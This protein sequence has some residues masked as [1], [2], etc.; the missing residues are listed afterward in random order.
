MTQ[1]LVAGCSFSDYTKVQ[2]VY[3]E[4]LFEKLKFKKYIHEARGCG[5]NYRMW[6]EIVNHV[7]KKTIFPED[8]I[9]IQYTE[10]IR[11]EYW[12][13]H[14]R[15]VIP[16]TDDSNNSDPYKN[17]GTIIRFKTDS[18]LSQHQPI[19]KRFFKSLEYFI[20]ED[21]ENEKFYVNHQ[22]FQAFMIF[23]NFKNVFFLK[24]GSYGPDYDLIAEYKNNFINGS[25]LLDHPY[26][27]P[28]DNWHLS[29]EGHEN[30]ANFLYNFLKDNKHV[31]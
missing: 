18:H 10:S 9:I 24:G 31:N 15:A 5:S 16:I 4:I 19:E 6:R 2:K 23:N 21:F 27:L 22:M 30:T 13:P 20:N 11:Q 12:T 25:H 28:G 3:G 14:R 29:Q 7:L 1:L 26:H 17:S 8:F